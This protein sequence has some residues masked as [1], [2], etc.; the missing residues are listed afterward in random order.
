MREHTG[1]LIILL[2]A[3]IVRV[4]LYLI[5]NVNNS[6]GSDFYLHI[7]SPLNDAN[8]Y[9]QLALNILNTSS[10]S[11]NS[12]VYIF[13]FFT[14]DSVRTPGYPV[15]LAFIYLLFGVSPSLV[16]IFQ[17]ALNLA[18]IYLVYSIA[19]KLFSN[20]NIALISAFLFS[21]DIYTLFFIFELYTETLFVFTLLFSTVLFIKSINSHGFLHLIIS[22]ILIGLSA[23]IRPIAIFLPIV[24]IAII[25]FF[26]KHS[27]SLKF[28]K[29]GVLSISFLLIISLWM[30]RN[31]NEYSHFGFS[32]ISS[33]NLYLFNAAITKSNS[34]DKN[35]QQII[36]EFK[37]I[38]IN[39]GASK[40]NNAFDNAEIFKM[41]G[42]EYIKTNKL[43]FIKQHFLGML[44]MYLSIGHRQL[45]N[46]LGFATSEGGKKYSQSNLRRLLNNSTNMEIVFAFWLIAFLIFCYVFASYGIFSMLKTKEYFSIFLLLGLIFYFTFLTG[47]GGSPRFRIPVVPFYSMLAGYGFV[48]LLKLNFQ[49]KVIKFVIQS[50]K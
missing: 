19:A 30:M 14:L 23:L 50:R 26:D 25:F 34:T 11:G 41:L 17:I 4:V 16:I 33:V 35:T 6:P 21:L 24:Y 49:T 29:T 39:A 40:Q 32:T 46:R 15:F 5:L 13:D 36:N 9:H 45:L 10:F 37:N 44:N 47:V 43:L 7:F 48:K 12:P 22:G 31:Y 1:I 20:K 2:L 42:K 8:G 18:S 28:F 38:A 3:L 27:V